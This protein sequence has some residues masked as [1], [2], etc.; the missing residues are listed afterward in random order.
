MPAKY[1]YS[2]CIINNHIF[3]VR[4]VR[5]L[6]D[7]KK[8]MMG[9]KFDGI[10]SGMLFVP[11]KPLATKNPN[12]AQTL[13]ITQTFWM[14]N[15]IIPLD[16]IFIKNGKI[17]NIHHSCPP[18]PQGVVDCPTYKGVGDLVLELE[19][20]MSKRLQFKK[21]QTVAMKALA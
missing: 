20:G 19:G 5:A 10:F 14:K 1:E 16:V 8:G 4:V 2:N 11:I 6:N 21:G 18:C 17:N 9:R 15:C 7:I 3:K 13:P 12:V